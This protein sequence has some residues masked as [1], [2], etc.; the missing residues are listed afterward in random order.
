ME[1]HEKTDT[2]RMDGQ[3]DGQITDERTALSTSS[4]QAS[5]GSRQAAALAGPRR[6]VRI[7]GPPPSTAAL[8]QIIKSP[9]PRGTEIVAAGVE[10]E[11]LRAPLSHHLRADG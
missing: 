3:T 6:G 5:A 1:G 8:L 2:G 9:P 10:P 7:T 11:P 4:S